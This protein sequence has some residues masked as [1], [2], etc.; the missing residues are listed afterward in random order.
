MVH[1]FLC[2]YVKG[3]GQ[4]EGGKKGENGVW[5]LRNMVPAF[6]LVVVMFTVK[7]IVFFARSVIETNKKIG[8]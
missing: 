2:V 5:R 8:K 3:G 7:C 6:C 1:G 4:G